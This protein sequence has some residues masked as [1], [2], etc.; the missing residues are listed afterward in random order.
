MPFYA[1]KPSADFM[2][3]EG[4]VRFVQGATLSTI[5]TGLMEVVVGSYGAL[6][7]SASQPQF[8]YAGPIG[9]GALFFVAGYL[10]WKS[11]KSGFIVS[12]ILCVL[13]VAGQLA[14]DGLGRLLDLIVVLAGLVTLSFNFLGYTSSARIR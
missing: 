11:R 7:L 8:Y 13:I 4:K 12:A 9:V 14:F 1:D 5:L 10:S 3:L 2:R 6:Y